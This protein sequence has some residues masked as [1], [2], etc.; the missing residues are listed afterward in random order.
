M[1]RK[2]WLAW[3]TLAALCVLGAWPALADTEFR[4]RQ[5]TRSDVPPGK[6]QCDIRLRVDGEAEVSV[7]GDTVYVRT[8]SGRDA[9]DEGS[10]CN[11]PLPARNIQ[12]FG[13]E[14]HERRGEIRLL[15]SP[16]RDRNSAAVV[17]IRDSQGGE[18]LYGFRLSWA[19]TGP[20]QGGG[21]DMRPPDRR[22]DMQQPGP[23][24]GNQGWSDRGG[25]MRPPGPDRGRA[26]W[27][28]SVEFRGRGVGSYIRG[29]E[30]RRQLSN[31]EVSVDRDGIV[32]VSFDTS[33]GGP[34]AFMGRITS[35]DR[36]TLT[37]DVEAGDQRLG[38]RGPMIITLDN[39][40]QV[41][42]VSMQG[43]AERR[44]N[45]SLRWQRR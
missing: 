27:N 40:R 13:F 30:R 4:V 19:M 20:Y 42:S 29:N 24:R 31:A 41:S 35:V 34:L 26:G 17:L 11:V 8:I 10:E 38:L 18:G 12:N 6:G 39:R 43:A 28:D 7:R 33:F 44:D 25:E 45:L 9:R 15:S 36:G 21:G 32:R 3:S 1:G 37:A 5:M 22:D 2:L 14:I 16:S 23:D